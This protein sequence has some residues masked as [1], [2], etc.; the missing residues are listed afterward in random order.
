MVASDGTQ[1]DHEVDGVVVSLKLLL[2]SPLSAETECQLSQA[3]TR[4]MPKA[5]AIRSS[6]LNPRLRRRA[7]RP[8][9]E[10]FSS[11]YDQC[12]GGAAIRIRRHLVSRSNATPTAVPPPSSPCS[13]LCRCPR[14]VRSAASD[15]LA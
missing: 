15:P 2:G 8:R 11:A 9:R 13:F 7:R 4:A 10:A 5:E 14:D 1:G 12:R 6:F 3:L